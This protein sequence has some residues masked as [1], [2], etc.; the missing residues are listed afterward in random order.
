MTNLPDFDAWATTALASGLDVGRVEATLKMELKRAY[1]QGYY[2]G[3]R[4]GYDDGAEN[5]WWHKI[6]SDL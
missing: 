2:Q 3:K 6:E 4:E 1:L 5:A